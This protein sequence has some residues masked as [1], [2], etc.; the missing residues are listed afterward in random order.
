MTKLPAFTRASV[1]FINSVMMLPVRDSEPVWPSGK[2]GHF[3]ETTA[4]K[5]KD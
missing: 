3:S 2:K 5:E 1:S 4:S